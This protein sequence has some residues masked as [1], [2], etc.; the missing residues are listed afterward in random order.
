MSYGIVRV[1]KMTAGSVTGI[2][3]HDNREKESKTN[4]DINTELSGN[5]FEF[6]GRADGRSFR[7]AVNER[8]SELELKKAVR[9]DAIV[10]AQVLVTS[11]GFFF[12]D[13][14]YSDSTA[15]FDTELMTQVGDRDSV[16]EFF[17]DSYNFLCDRFGKDNVISATVHMDERTPHMHFN[18]VPVTS[19]KRLSA[20]DVLTPKSLTELQQ[21]FHEDIGL[22][23]GLLRGK[24]DKDRKH[25]DTQEYKQAMGEVEKLRS[26]AS[27]L[28]VINSELQERGITLEKQ[29]EA[30]TERLTGLKSEID[31]LRLEADTAK[32]EVLAVRSAVSE[33]QGR[34][35]IDQ[36][37]KLADK[38]N[39]DVA[40]DKR[41]NLLEKFIDTFGLRERFNQ[42]ISSLTQQRQKSRD[43]RLP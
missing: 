32:R 37:K 12:N 19:D 13:L 26:E 35:G 30:D 4:P 43:D 31:E 1:Q 25:L 2:Q 34:L 38:H 33:T 42:F 28:R 41:L 15:N 10:M 7:S 6:P 17:E 5:N 11:D 27:E 22:K 9:K 3:I 39:A 23:W 21:T 8:I 36:Y 29:L 16:R 20:K 24:K 14:A 40:K 18:F